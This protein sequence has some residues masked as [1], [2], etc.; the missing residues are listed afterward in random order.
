MY[1]NLIDMSRALR[2]RLAD[3]GAVPI[4]HLKPGQRGTLQLI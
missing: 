3:D 1:C 4:G 2:V